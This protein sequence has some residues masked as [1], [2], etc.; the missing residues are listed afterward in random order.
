MDELAR[1]LKTGNIK[2]IF[3]E[4]TNDGMVQFFRYV[5]VGGFAFVADW[6]TM[7]LGVVAGMNKYWAVATAFVAG[8]IVN[9]ILSKWLVFQEKSEK[10]NATGE[11]VMYGVVG[12]LGLLFTEILMYIQL[13][14]MEIHIMIAKVIAA[15]IV[16]LWNFIA[17]KVLLYQ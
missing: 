4:Q 14:W 12:L 13:E 8:L 5:F 7:M 6:C 15:A 3:Q 11:F 2:V 1:R 9:F 10:T 16:L 17:R